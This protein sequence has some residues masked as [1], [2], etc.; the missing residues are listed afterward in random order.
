MAMDPRKRQKK[1]ERRKAKEKARHKELAKRNPQDMASRIERAVTAPILHCCTSDELLDQGMSYVLVSRELPNGKVAFAAFL[2]DVCCLGVK[3]AM[4]DIAP[5]SRYD[6]QIYGKM[7]QDHNLVKLKPEAARKLVEGAVEYARDLG[8]PPHPDYRKAKLIFGDID[9]DACTDEL[10]YGKNGK[11][12]FIAGPHDTPGRCRQIISILTDRCGPD[13]FH[14]LMPV[15]PTGMTGTPL[16]RA[17][18]M[19]VDESGDAEETTL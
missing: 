10:V 8:F 5:R 11:P 2:L 12:F 15:D 6:W 3:N 17:R 7:F 4:V 18:L 19:M 13:G 1:L 14:F 16:G 9:T